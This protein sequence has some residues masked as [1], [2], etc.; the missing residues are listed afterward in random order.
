L[1]IVANL[2]DRLWLLAPKSSLR[3]ISYQP[4]PLLMEIA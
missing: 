1:V 3:D 2:I 4:L